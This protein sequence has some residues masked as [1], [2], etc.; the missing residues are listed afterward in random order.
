MKLLEI[1]NSVNKL[2][3]LKSDDKG[4]VSTIAKND[5]VFIENWRLV[6]PT[7]YQLRDSMDPE[8]IIMHP[9][10][11]H[12]ASGEPRVVKKLRHNINVRLNVA[13]STVVQS[14]LSLV[15]SP[16]LH[17]KLNPQQL[18]LLTKVQATDKNTA[19]KFGMAAVAAMKESADSAFV[20]IY[21]NRG[22]IHNGKKYA[23][24]G[25]VSFPF[26]R[27]LKEDQIEKLRVMDKEPFA[28]IMEFI[29]QDITETDAY[30][31]GSD[32]SFAPFFQALMLTI[33]NVAVRLNELMD[34]YAEFM[35]WSAEMPKESIYLEMGWLDSI[36]NIDTMGSD[37]A[38]VPR[39]NDGPVAV[40]AKPVEQVP[41]YSPAAVAPLRPIQTVPMKVASTVA[42]TIGSKAPM[43]FKTLM[44]GLNQNQQP[45]QHPQM[46][47]GIHQGL[48]PGVMMTPQGMMIQTP[49]GLMPFVPQM[50]PQQP[51][52]P[53]GYPNPYAQPQQQNFMMPA[54]YG[55]MSP[56][57]NTPSW[58][59]VPPEQVMVM[60]ANNGPMTQAMAMQLQ[61]QYQPIQQQPMQQAYNPNGTPGWAR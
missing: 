23:R 21:L 20:N 11:E 54:G 47:P 4:F 10:A 27:K 37:I 12:V 43:D 36:V 24:L 32:S 49:Q 22:G 60:T 16:T 44:A 2:A 35:P 38:A 3:G 18:E 33:A 61:L 48:P 59:Q 17:K 56:V 14:L 7:S 41:V 31:V 53:Q 52:M 6:L 26:Y 15:V 50:Q 25:V 8:R 55:Q 28:Q 1:Y 39:Q 13:I 40:A 30:N 9:M 5:P 42:Q 46:M 29:F 57:N 51:M 34:L 45:Q 58:A 19:L